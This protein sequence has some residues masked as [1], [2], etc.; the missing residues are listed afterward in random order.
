VALWPLLK[1]ISLTD[2][3]DQPEPK[4]SQYQYVDHFISPGLMVLA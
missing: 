2:F 1:S 3:P 4:H